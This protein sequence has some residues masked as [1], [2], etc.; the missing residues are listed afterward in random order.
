MNERKFSSSS[1]SSLSGTQS[2]VYYCP[3]IYQRA[4]SRFHSDQ[5]GA[6]NTIP[7][8]NFYLYFDWSSGRLRLSVEWKKKNNLSKIN[9]LAAAATVRERDC[10]RSKNYVRIISVWRK[11]ST[12]RNDIK[13]P[14]VD[15][16]AISSRFSFCVV[17]PNVL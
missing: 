3:L 11:R 17:E 7:L 4:R 9:P 16:L 6:N 5:F 10:R 12:R 8:K 14:E 13:T 15:R 2:I 1:S